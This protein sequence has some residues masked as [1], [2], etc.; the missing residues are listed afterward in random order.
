VAWLVE[1]RKGGLT[2]GVC[3]ADGGANGGHADDG[4]CY[5]AGGLLVM[6]DD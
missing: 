6:L 3:C 4:T 2:H 5:D 1:R